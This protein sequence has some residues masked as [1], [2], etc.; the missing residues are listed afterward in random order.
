VSHAGRPARRLPLGATVAIVAVLVAAN[1]DL[2]SERS[3][4][5]AWQ[6]ELE[7]ASERCDAGADD[8]RIRVAPEPFGFVLEAACRDL[9]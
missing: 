1:F 9:R 6:P 4:G 3:L 5:P 7:A 2:T 8:A